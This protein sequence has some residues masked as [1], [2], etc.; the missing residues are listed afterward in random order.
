[1]IAGGCGPMGAGDAAPSGPTLGA[2]QRTVLF[3]Q[4]PG[5]P[6]PV[7]PPMSALRRPVGLPAT[8]CAAHVS[9]F[10]QS[11]ECT[12]ER[13]GQFLALGDF[14]P[15]IKPFIF[16]YP[17]GIAPVPL[18][19]CAFGGPAAGVPKRCSLSTGCIPRTNRIV[20][21]FP[22]DAHASTTDGKAV[23]LPNYPRDMPLVS[24]RGAVFRLE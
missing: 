10:N 3:C 15:Y 19:R 21:V 2:L 23:G 9:G 11:A 13:I 18:R 17:A 14:P 4:R 12:C 1:M 24:G 16:S 7:G 20:A 5:D 22:C 8:A 6:A